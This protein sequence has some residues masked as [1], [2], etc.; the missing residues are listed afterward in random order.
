M[1]DLTSS[2]FWEA[3]GENAAQ[4]QEKL[5]ALAVIADK[6]DAGTST[7]AERLEALHLVVNLVIGRTDA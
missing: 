2:P 3:F 7:A 6:L 5:A 4:T 1:P